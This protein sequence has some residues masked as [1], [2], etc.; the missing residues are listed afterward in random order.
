MVDVKVDERYHRVAQSQFVAEVFQPD[1][2]TE[3]EHV[4]SLKHITE[5]VRAQDP[6]E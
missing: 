4:H 3:V 6:S 1:V 5:E 2:R